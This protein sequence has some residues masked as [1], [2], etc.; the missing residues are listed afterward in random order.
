VVASRD[1]KAAFQVFPSCNSP[2]FFVLS[3]SIKAF[4]SIAMAGGCNQSIYAEFAPIVD[5]T[6]L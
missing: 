6:P 4:N 2:A 3:H 1:E 5:N